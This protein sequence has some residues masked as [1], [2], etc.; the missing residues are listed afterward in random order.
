M[1]H[2]IATQA[3][4][5]LSSQKVAATVAAA[6]AGSG[7]AKELG[8]I[9]D[10]FGVIGLVLAAVLSSV[11]ILRHALGVKKDLYEFRMMKI[12][13]AEHRGRREEDTEE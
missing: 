4:S 1:K 11:L 2:E 5:A 8:Y 7:L 3:A 9:N 10:W 13:D 12:R 6:T